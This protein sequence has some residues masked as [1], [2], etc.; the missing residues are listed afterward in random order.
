SRWFSRLQPLTRTR[1][2]VWIG[3]SCSLLHS[4]IDLSVETRLDD[5]IGFEQ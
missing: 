3:S 1:E 5:Q 4:P 2:Q